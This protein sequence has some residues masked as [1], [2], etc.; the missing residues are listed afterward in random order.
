MSGPL[1]L[2]TLRTIKKNFSR[3]LSIL[4]MV[5]LGTAF[6]VGMKATAPDM[7]DNAETYFTDCNLMDIRV[8]STIGL[9][10]TD[11]EAL[12]K[13][14][15]VEFLSS[16]KFTDAFVSVNGVPELDIDGTRITTRVY[17]VSTDKLY[18]YTHNMDDGDYINRVEL[19]EGRFPQKGECL[20]DASR[21]STPE[22]Y[23]LGSIITLKNSG[24]ETPE[25]L[26]TDTFTIV[27]IVRSPYYL[28]FERGNTDIG[29]GKL[30][31][32]II[33]PEQAF[34]TDYYSEV[35]IKVEGSDEYEPFSDD[36]FSHVDE[37]KK[38]IEYKS[39]HL[40]ANRVSDL[41]PTLQ[42][43]IST[44]EAEIS[45]KEQEVALSLSDLNATII[46]LQNLVDN[47][48]SIMQ[49]AQDKFNEEFANVD[50]TLQY[51]T[52]AYQNA[53]T[54]YSEQS[55][56]LNNAKAEYNQ[57]ALELQANSAAYDDA[58]QEYNSK[59]A[60]LESA[61]AQL[62]NTQSMLEAAKSM[63]QRVEDMG[64]SNMSNEQAQSLL[65]LIQTTNPELYNT[66][67]GMSAQGLATEVLANLEPYIEQETAEL[68]KQQQKLDEATALLA[69]QK[70]ILDE[71]KLELET[72]A[73]QSNQAQVALSDAENALRTYEQVLQNMGVKLQ[74]A[75][76]QATIKKLEA[77][78]QLKELQAQLQAAPA[79]LDTA[80][81]TKASV[82]AQ[83]ETGL[84]Y[85]KSKLADAK[86][87]YAKLDDVEWD[88]YDRGDTPG[89][90]GYGQAVANIEVI[91]NIFPIFFFIISSLV[92][93]TTV[94]RLVDEDRTLIGTYK[95]LGYR[96]G[97]ILM[98]YVLYSLLA[99]LLG[100]AL[101]MG[102][103]YR[104]I[105]MAVSAAY[106][107]MY[108]LPAM[109]YSFPVNWAV[110]GLAIALLSTVVV[111]V[112]A[113]LGNLRLAPAKLMRPKAPKKGR[114]ILLEHI[115]FIWRS[116]SF[117]RKVT[118]R[119]LFRN[120][121]RF[122]MTLV[123]IAGCTA[124]LLGSVGFYNSISAIKGKQYDGADAISKYDL[125]VVFDNPQTTP[126]HTTEYTAVSLDARV[127]SMNLISMKSTNAFS[128]RA[129]KKLETYVLVPENPERLTDFFA[130]HDRKA[131]ETSY[132][133][134]DDG[135]IITEKLAKDTKTEVGDE[136]SFTDAA[137]N[138]YKV[139]VAAI[140]ENYT[141]HYIFLSPAL[142]QKTVGEAPVFGYAIGT[143]SE[144]LKATTGSELDAL[145]GLL[146][147]DFMR[148]TGVT[149]VAFT[150][151]TTKSI[152]EITNA[153]SLVIVIFFVSALVLAIVVLYNLA[154][155]NIIERTRELATL[156]VLGFNESEVGRYILRENMMVSF[157]G[158][159]CGVGLG[160]GLHKLLITYTAID[161]VMYGQEIH[162]WAYALAVGITVA[163][164][165]AVNLLLRKKTRRIDMVE[166]L[167]SVE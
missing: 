152:G 97:S 99:G 116:L 76:L 157:F 4:L 128:D 12:S 165:A 62:E 79:Q 90:T 124:M 119:N 34:S 139:P 149:T 16:E 49:Q 104:L 167:K 160:I 91:S 100:A 111:T 88:I 84:A 74:D 51:N 30:G 31:T 135:A 145:K 56:A 130:L 143:L 106:S 37:V 120:K 161:T 21:L 38:Q 81:A 112:L 146:A 14:E 147:T 164:I 131:P 7:Y 53:I 109:E 26:N 95:A 159:L 82:E 134:T 125:Q 144:S 69:A 47:G 42:K 48:D 151:E 41:R 166:S 108:D 52:E 118:L 137:G 23:R 163:I 10:D 110:V 63:M 94:T 15:G 29:S 11:L 71:K 64:V 101:G 114:R 65:T 50:A 13:V 103:G 113:V 117:S 32:F 78:N 123:G 96:N 46:T 19:I 156:K 66:I 5:A 150:S 141:F 3:F 33:V 121:S 59:V 27:G 93:L 45:S 140:A 20:V 54:E 67:R 2:D 9:T 89:Y 55:A 155:I 162:W 107:I 35:Y 115:P 86:L 98:K 127:A 28:S 22:S 105:P 36:Y 122:F 132:T 68:A 8:R 1:F 73:I 77:Q 85:A 18:N 133:L 24:D 6:F 60:S 136:I 17:G 25:A 58:L 39:P 92:V 40:I 61:R 75:N 142:Y 158:I 153:L 87:L 148:Q 102:L 70:T 129:S 72:A 83:L 80:L 44:A 126:V 154:N 43:E 138:V 57:K